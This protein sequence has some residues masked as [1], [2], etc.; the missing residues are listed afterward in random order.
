MAQ[1]AGHG[2]R[3]RDMAQPGQPGPPGRGRRKRSCCCA[4][5]CECVLLL[6][7]RPSSHLVLIRILSL[8]QPHSCSALPS[9][10][11]AKTF[12]SSMLPVTCRAVDP[13]HCRRSTRR[14]T[15]PIL[16]TAGLTGTADQRLGHIWPRQ[17]AESFG[18]ARGDGT[19]GPRGAGLGRGAAPAAPGASPPCVPATPPPPTAASCPWR[20]RPASPPTIQPEP[21]GSRRTHPAS[22]SSL[23]QIHAGSATLPA[24]GSIRFRPLGGTGNGQGR[25]RGSAAPAREK[26]ASFTPQRREFGTVLNPLRVLPQRHRA[27]PG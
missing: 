4:R 16:L 24:P 21:T 13:A 3:Q 6:L 2:Q 15:G 18:G 25:P 9:L 20:L 12:L 19:G 10:P 22:E 5:C 17:A 23:T 14:P 27:M 1:A 26:V 7:P 8:A 11:L